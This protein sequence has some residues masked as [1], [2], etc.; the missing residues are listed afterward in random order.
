MN[1]PPDFTATLGGVPWQIRFVRRGHEKVPECWGMCYWDA[2]EIYVRYDL[3]RETVRD[4]LIHEMLHA[5]CRLL[6]VAEEW[7][8]HTATEINTGLERAGL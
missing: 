1:R 6:F 2:R 3:S 5:T 8:T 4:T 7:V